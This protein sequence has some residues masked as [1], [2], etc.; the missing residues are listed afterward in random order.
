MRALI[1]PPQVSAIDCFY[2]LPV[3]TTDSPYFWF[4]YIQYLRLLVQV[5]NW[6]SPPPSTPYISPS[7]DSRCRAYC[8]AAR[9][10]FKGAGADP[11]RAPLI[12]GDFLFFIFIY[13]SIL[14][15]SQNIEIAASHAKKSLLIQNFLERYLDPRRSS[16]G[17]RPSHF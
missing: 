2:Y 16:L 13:F 10:G 15:K 7:R 3:S 4:L 14:F 5:C 1:G 12:F 8:T 9:R 17:L 6:P 11:A